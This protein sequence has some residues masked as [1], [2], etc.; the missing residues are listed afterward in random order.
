MNYRCFIICITALVIIDECWVHSIC[1]LALYHKQDNKFIEEPN[2]YAEIYSLRLK[3]SQLFLHTK[4]MS[5]YIPYI[6]K[7]ETLILGWR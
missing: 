1:H 2:P 5:R 7:T 4:N 3:V 6:D